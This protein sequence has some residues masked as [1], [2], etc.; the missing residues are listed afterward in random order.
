[1]SVKIKFFLSTLILVVVATLVAC[2][3][4]SEEPEA[5]KAV[6]DEKIIVVRV[7]GEPVYEANVLRRIR[8]AHGGDIEEV[9]KDPNR[10]QML[11]DVA[12]ETEVMDK[13]LLQAALADG[14]AVSAEEARELLTRTKDVAGK[15]AFSEMLAAREA[16]EEALR[17]FLVERELINRYKDKLFAG[18]VVDED[19]LRNYYEGHAETF[20]DPDK[21]RLEVFTFG[22][23]ETA[24]KI[25]A[26]LKSGESF[27][28]I[29][30]A[31]HDE[32]EQVGRRTRWMPMNAVP[33]EL[34][35]KVTEAEAGTIL[36]PTQVFDTFYVV[37]VVEKKAARI[38]GIE[39]VK[40]E[41]GK[42]I[43]TIRQNKVLDEWY[44]AA[45]LEATIEY[46]H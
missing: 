33:A 40:D 11:L 26:R 14:M 24:K 23:R 18:L 43:L 3:P 8:A 12:T 1:M 13:L 27:D 30:K 42:T 10:W 17:D 9:K 34:R 46:V 28:S 37:R 36:E 7:N 2:T 41:I 44:K 29:A 45:S 31:Y 16:N 6:P 15:L 21:V 4:D 22:V 32:A 5:K 20:A 39:E 25:Y 19:A 38:R 35:S